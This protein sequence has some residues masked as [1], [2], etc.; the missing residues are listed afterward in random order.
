MNI[1]ERFLVIAED[2]TPSSVSRIPLHRNLM[3]LLTRLI[4]QSDD[5]WLIPGL[6]LGGK[7]R[8]RSHALS[9]RGGRWVRTNVSKDRTLVLY[10]LRHTFG[11]ALENAG[12]SE[13]MISRLMRHSQTKL[14]FSV[15]SAGPDL[16]I[17]RAA[18]DQ[19]PFT[20]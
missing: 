2:K 4:E 17:M 6:S 18:I 9:K 15:Y 20:V 16:A 8:R 14:T 11:T 10:T 12:V 1:A 3:L 19:L 7:D 13:L 5:Q